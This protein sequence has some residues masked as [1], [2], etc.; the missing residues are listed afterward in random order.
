MTL[1]Q[2]MLPLQVAVDPKTCRS[3]APLRIDL[4]CVLGYQGLNKYEMT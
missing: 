2:P 3:C 1:I 4:R